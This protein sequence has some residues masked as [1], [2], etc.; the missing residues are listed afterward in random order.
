MKIA[1]LLKLVSIDFKVVFSFYT[2]DM[3]DIIIIQDPHGNL[4]NIEIIEI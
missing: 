1:G 3:Y 4:L 2:M